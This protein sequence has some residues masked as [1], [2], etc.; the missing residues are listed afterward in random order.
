M[1]A[2][3]RGL[4]LA[5]GLG[6][7]VLAAPA[8]LAAQTSLTVTPLAVTIPTP[9]ATEFDNT[10]SAVASLTYTVDCDNTAPCRIMVRGAAFNG[11]PVSDV[12]WTTSP[13]GPWTPLSTTGAR[14]ANHPK[15]KVRSGTIYFRIRISYT[16][17]PPGTYTPQVF[18]SV[19]Q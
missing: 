12:E 4:A 2:A 16:T 19:E 3:A 10:A 5:L 11:R 1:A 18:V 17:Y 15:N 8:S 7:A 13:G 6:G 9:G 14:V